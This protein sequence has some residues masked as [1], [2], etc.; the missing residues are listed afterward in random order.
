MVSLA[1]IAGL[2]NERL[3]A[4]ENMTALKNQRW[5]ILEETLSWGTGTC[6]AL[7][8][9]YKSGRFGLKRA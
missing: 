8:H 2:A 7:H 4:S 6:L 3:H 1:D 9:E 5:G